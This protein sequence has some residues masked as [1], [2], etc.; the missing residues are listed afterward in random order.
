[1]VCKTGI[2]FEQFINIM[3]LARLSHCH[4]RVLKMP[5]VVVAN[6]TR[7]MIVPSL[8]SSVLGVLAA[9]LILLPSNATDLVIVFLSS[10]SVLPRRMD[11]ILRNGLKV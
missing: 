2:K 7:L 4:Q 11:V 5:K 9:V 3:E 1:M 6:F 10:P 8:T